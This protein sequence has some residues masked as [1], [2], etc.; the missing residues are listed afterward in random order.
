MITENL[1]KISI[2]PKGQ[3]VAGTYERLDLVTNAGSS[4]LSL[5][6]ENSSILTVTADW[7]LVAGKGDAFEYSDF[8]PEQI[9]VLQ[10]PATDIAST[11]SQAEGLRVTAE[12]GR[13][14]AEGLRVTAESNRAGAESLRVTAEQTRQTNTETAIQ[15]AANATALAV[16]VA[17]HPDTIINDYWWRWNTTTNAYENTGIRAKGDVYYST[18]SVNLETGKLEMTYDTDFTNTNFSINNETGQ[19]ILTI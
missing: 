5:K 18:F 11:V 1:G 3:W 12:S 10:Q 4:Y 6:D 13:V 15:N 2:T 7:M 8:T 9:E 16:E 19:L 17:E 14:T